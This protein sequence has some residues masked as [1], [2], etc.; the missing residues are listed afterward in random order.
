MKGESVI[1]LCDT[2]SNYECIFQAGVVRKQCEFYIEKVEEIDFIAE[3]PKADMSKV[4]TI[5][6]NGKEYVSID[7]I[8]EIIDEEVAIENKAIR[9]GESVDGSETIERIAIR[10][11]SL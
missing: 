10:I 1:S 9:C 3:H 5:S 4:N 7:R 8:L 11:R 2:C 6:V